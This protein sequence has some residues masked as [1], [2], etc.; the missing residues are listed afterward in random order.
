MPT[1]IFDPDEI[2]AA[3][4]AGGEGNRLG[5]RDKGLVEVAGRPLVAHAAASLSGQAA[6]I[7][8]C[9]NRNGDQYA[10]FGHVV[11]DAA[12]GFRGP[13][14]GI[15]AA[16]AACSTPWLLTI[17]VDAPQPPLDLARRL[18]DAAVVAHVEAAVAFEDAQPQPMFALYRSR[19]AES[20][21]T[22]LAQDLPVW[23]WQQQIR[24]SEVF[25][26]AELRAFVNLN[27]A[28]DIAA[29][30]LAHARA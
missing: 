24:A 6:T 23:R 28:E 9:A 29:W 30:E 14:A 25:F 1:Q 4:L 12:P 18:F 20:A 7:L 26:D 16:L 5:G 11:P 8:V 15:A 10:R 2:T 3:I 22:A 27:T 17:P 19:L 21:A 13:L